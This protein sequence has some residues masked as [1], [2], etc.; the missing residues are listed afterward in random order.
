MNEDIFKRIADEIKGLHNGAIEHIKRGEYAEAA[1]QYRKALMITEKISYYEGMAITLFNMANLAIVVGDLIEA[2]KNVADAR[3][4]FEKAQL[5]YNHCCKL[6]DQL[7]VSMKKRGIEYEKKGKFLEAIEHFEAC[8]PFADKRSEQAMLHEIG[9][10]KRII[11][12]K[13]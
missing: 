11:N 7:V 6:I 4:M 5:P 8:I 9:L 12:K 13:T 10:L 2:M 3:D 1:I